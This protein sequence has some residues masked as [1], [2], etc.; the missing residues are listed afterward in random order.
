MRIT[1]VLPHADLSG[2][3]RVAAIYAQR[4]Q[5]R[6]HEVQA[7][8]SAKRAPP[9]GFKIRSWLGGRGWPR[10]RPEPSHFDGLDVPHRVLARWRPITADD[11]PDADVVIATWWETAEWV[12]ALPPRKGAKVYF[13]QH[14]EAWDPATMPRVEATWRLPLQKLAVS[15]WLADLARDRFDDAFARVV[16]NGVDTA[17]FQA[18][19]RGKQPVPTV[20]FMYSTVAFKGCD[21]SLAAIHAARRT[22]PDLRVVAFGSE[23]P[24][25]GLPLPTGTLFRRLPAQSELCNIYA[26]C[27]AWLFGSRSEGFGLPILEAMACRTPVLGTPT[28]AAPELLADGAGVLVP[29]ADAAGLAAAIERVSRMP[30]AEWR[31]M[32]ERAY[33]RARRHTW[34]AATD[35]FEAGLWFALER[36]R[37]GEIAGGVD[38]TRAPTA[39]RIQRPSA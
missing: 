39:L 14:F 7:I 12:M 15:R 11:V 6:G 34:T 22:V 32:S 35:A 2:G 26:A 38:G 33:N 9:L 16:P 31:A 28:G 5:Q 1:F 17:Q 37:R 3:I 24:A 4:L 36:C 23:G 18:P 8:S 27:D 29:E 10:I 21:L 19:P 20:G 30:E 13:L 25:P